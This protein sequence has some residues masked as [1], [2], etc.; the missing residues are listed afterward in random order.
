MGVF[1]QNMFLKGLTQEKKTFSRQIF[2]SYHFIF[3]NIFIWFEYSLNKWYNLKKCAKI[4][5]ILM[6]FSRFFFHCFFISPCHLKINRI[7]QW[8]CMLTAFDG[9]ISIASCASLVSI[10]V[11]VIHIFCIWCLC[12][13][14]CFRKFIAR[15]FSIFCL[16]SN[17][18]FNRL[19]CSVN[20]INLFKIDTQSI[21]LGFSICI[22]LCG[23]A[24]LHTEE[25]M[26]LKKNKYWVKI[27]K[28]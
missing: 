20:S 16:F 15:C 6:G 13:R 8:L 3:Y 11:R 10:C 4:Q 14:R 12:L 18:S 7:Y 23:N 28:D 27:D 9:P 26:C 1:F 24:S 2:N 25:K 17:N 19:Y 22:L 5:W 21:S